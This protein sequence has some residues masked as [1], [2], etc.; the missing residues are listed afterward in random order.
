MPK[1]SNRGGKYSRRAIGIGILLVVIVA[2]S[3]LKLGVSDD[4][5]ESPVRQ[6]ES[7]RGTTPAPVERVEPEEIV[8]GDKDLI[9]DSKAIASAD[10]C[11]IRSGRGG[12]RSATVVVLK[13]SESVRFSVFDSDGHLV[14]DSLPFDPNHVYVAKRTDGSVL[15]AFGDLRLNSKVTRGRE[16]EEPVRIYL[17]DQVVYESP[18]AWNLGIARD[19]S[20]FYIV[21]P[22]AS[23]TSRLIVHD[24]NM[25]TEHQ[26][27]LGY[28]HTSSFD[29]LPFTVRFTKDGK[30]VAFISSDTLYFYPVD[31]GPV[32]T[33]TITPDLG[34]GAVFE[35][36]DFAYIAFRD[37]STGQPQVR[38]LRFSEDSA[39]SPEVIW[40]KTMDAIDALYDTSLMLSEDGPWLILDAWNL[41]VLNTDTGEIAF[42]FPAAGNAEA[43]RERLG[44]VMAGQEKDE[45]GAFRGVEIMQDQ[46]VIRRRFG[47]EEIRRCNSLVDSEPCLRDLREQGIYYE[48]LDMFPIEDGVIAH[49]PT[50]RIRLPAEPDCSQG[51]F[52]SEVLV[53]DEQGQ[54]R[55]KRVEP[56]M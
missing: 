14:S 11:R 34:Y 15:T 4:P 5:V 23:Q 30:A 52:S 8:P 36:A 44:P 22:Q 32:R 56:N 12:D 41:H 21:D 47:S 24:V 37:E 50:R 26:F 33:A 2:V 45:L 55:H 46:L 29:E 27:D 43:A 39:K 3:I 7:E 1:E 54:L 19:G 42:T 51:Y 25:G 48:A 9:I 38:K 6:A 17:D 18:K 49:Y 40:S 35:S 53:S 16:T 31:G 10:E 13:E 28:Q 20:S